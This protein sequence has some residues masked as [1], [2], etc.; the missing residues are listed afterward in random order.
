[1]HQWIGSTLVKIT[2][3]HL[4]GAKPLSRPML[5]YCQL[6]LSMLRNKLHRNFTKLFIHEKA[7]ENIVCIMEAI[8]SRGRWVKDP[9]MMR[10]NMSV[11]DMGVV[12]LPSDCLN[13]MDCM[14]SVQWSMTSII[15]HEWLMSVK[16]WNSWPH[17]R[18]CKG[19][20]IWRL[21]RSTL[22]EWYKQLVLPID[23]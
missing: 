7:S 6:D 8:L 4:F 1:M 15:P 10:M 19:N 3:C 23:H 18:M 13:I 14:S 2:A 16:Y 17:W 5:V 21:Y 9:L 12:K 20:R 11:S 22:V